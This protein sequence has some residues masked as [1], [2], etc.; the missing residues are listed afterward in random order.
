MLEG[1]M[2]AEVDGVGGGGGGYA[3]L[4]GVDSAEGEQGRKDDVR[5]VGWMDDDGVARLTRSLTLICARPPASRCWLFQGKVT[6]PS[7]CEL[8]FGGGHKVLQRSA[9]A[10]R[11]EESSN[12]SRA[13]ADL[14]DTTQPASHH[15]PQH[16]GGGGGDGGGDSGRV[17]LFR[18]SQFRTNQYL[19][20]KSIS[21]PW[22]AKIQWSGGLITAN[23]RRHRR[24]EREKGLKEFGE[25]DKGPCGGGAGGGG[26]CC[27]THWE[28]STD[29]IG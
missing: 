11:F 29:W 28:H 13:A 27:N 14:S 2:D 21:W 16:S 23:V 25:I 20:S 9:D 18:R 3:S 4:C 15:R 24:D 7:A 5:I 10:V 17:Y 26:R 19:W 1:K 22:R 6:S 12:R 8:A